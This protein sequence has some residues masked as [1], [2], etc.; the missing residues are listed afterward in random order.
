MERW[1]VLTEGD[2]PFK[3]KGTPQISSSVNSLPIKDYLI[4]FREVISLCLL[5]VL[6]CFLHYSI[7][8]VLTCRSFRFEIGDYRYTSSTISTLLVKIYEYFVLA[9]DFPLRNYTY[10]CR[11]CPLGTRHNYFCYIGKR[12]KS[13]LE[14]K[15]TSWNFANKFLSGLLLGKH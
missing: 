1:T 15:L 7:T 10:W 2:Y 6:S 13:L 14:A 3:E 4:S 5:H 12:V 8:H 9:R 11:A